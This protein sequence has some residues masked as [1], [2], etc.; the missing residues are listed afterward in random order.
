LVFMVTEAPLGRQ[1]TSYEALLPRYL[2][3]SPSVR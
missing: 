2:P 3:G 1:I